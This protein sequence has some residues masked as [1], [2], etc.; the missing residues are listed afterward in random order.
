MK[1][2]GRYEDADKYMNQFAEINANDQRAKLFEGEPDYL[3]RI[4]FQSG[5]FEIENVSINSSF[6]DFGAAFYAE[7]VVFASSRD[8]LLFRKN[9]HEWNEEPFLDLYRA[10]IDTT[11]GELPDIQKFD[12]RLNSKFHESTPVFTKDGTTVYF[13]RNNYDDRRYGNDKEGTNKLKIYRAFKNTQGNWT[14]PQSLSFNSDEYSTAHP[15]LSIDEKTLYFSSDMPGGMGQSDLY[16]VTVNADGSF[17]EPQNLGDRINTEGKETF[18]FISKSGDLY[19]ASNGH[20]GLGGL[21]IFVT[22]IEPTTEEEALIVNI[23]KPVNSPKDDFAFIVDEESRRGYF[24]SNRDGGRGRDDIYSFLQLEDLKSFCETSIVGVVRDSETD[25]IISGARVTIFDVSNNVIETITVGNDGL[26]T[27]KEKI[28]CSTKYFVRIE[29]DNYTT[30]EMMVETSDSSEPLD[31]SN[32]MNLKLIREV[33]TVTVGDDLA[34]KLNLQPIYFDF[35]QSSI[36]KDAAVELA[37]VIEV[38]NQYPQMKIEVRSH[39][40]SR[41]DDNYNLYLSNRRAKATI[42]CMIDK[43]IAPDRLIG[44]GYGEKKLA[45]DCTNNSPCPDEK[46]QQSRRSEFVIIQ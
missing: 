34:Q 22:H 10:R 18:P 11:N 15:T 33:R 17:G 2:A 46:N 1:T 21:D 19:F 25:E 14:T 36:R 16:S 30:A 35:N 6:T 40:D 37:K 29:K 12:D 24:S 45:N 7:F 41:G 23:G 38:M 13:T 4:D 44:K 26:Y 20:S 28:K 43:G 8:R 3:E 39:T 27:T 42:K 32:E 31:L 9:V 5:R